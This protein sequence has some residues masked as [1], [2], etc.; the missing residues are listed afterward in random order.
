VGRSEREL[1]ERDKPP[2]LADNTGDMDSRSTAA[3]MERKAIE[4]QDNQE[5]QF[6]KR[7]FLSGKTLEP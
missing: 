7:E 5:I 6:Q 1:D 3:I 2:E 4:E